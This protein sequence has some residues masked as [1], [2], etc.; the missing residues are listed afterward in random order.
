MILIKDGRVIDPKSGMDEPLDI[1]IRDGIIAGMG[2][3]QKSDDYDT[4][5]D[6]RG[7]VVAPGL[8]DAHVH[9]RDPGFTYKEDLESGARAAAAGGYTTVVCMAN[10]NRVVDCKEVLWDLRKR[11][12]SLPIRVLNAAA[13]TVGLKSQRLTDME[14]LKQAGAV[15]FTDD[16]IPIKNVQLVLEAMRK[17]KQLGVPLSFHEEDPDLVGSPGINAGKIAQAMG[18]EGASSL[19]EETLIARDCLLALKTGAIINIQHISS[20]VSVELIRMM[21]GLGARVYAEVTPQHFPLNE[22]AVLEKGTLAKVNPPLRTEED[23]Y[24]LIQGLK[25]DVIDMIAT[26]HAPH[27]REEKAK[28]IEEAP[29]GMIGLET[30]LALGI[31]YLV[32]KGHMTLPHLLEKMTVKPA[33]LYQLDSGSLKVGARADLIVFDEREKWVAERFH[34]KSENSPFIGAELVGKIKYTICSGQV[35]YMDEEENH[36]S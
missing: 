8:I 9:F 28:G 32:R 15:G 29:S 13:V 6:A 31:T 11:A 33:E 25:D 35:V 1:I 16:G 5:I 18:V 27:S 23:R 10:T 12:A 30:A 20:K 2:K 14:A 36:E 17:S 34:S 3:F 24:A 22:E 19:A 26:D 4:V 21:K 7:K